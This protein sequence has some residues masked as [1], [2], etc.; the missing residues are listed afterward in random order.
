[1]SN[2]KP[3]SS[4]TPYDDVFR[5]LLNDCSSLIIPVINEVFG[6]DYRGD[7]EVL[8][9]PNEHFIQGQDTSTK[10]KI[11]D[12][13]FQ[14]IGIR[15][16]KYHLECQSTTDNK[17][18]VRMFEY[19]TQIALDAGEVVQGTL[20][21]EFPHS[22]VL[23]LRHN[24]R[25]PDAMTVRIKTP[26]GEISYQ[27]LV[28]KT[29]QYT[30]DE[31]F[32]KKLLFLIPFYIFTHE[33]RF[34]E[35]ENNADKRELLRTEVIG[36]MEKLEQMASTGEISE[37]EKCTIV[38]MS[39]KVVEKIAAKYE[40]V[41]K[42]VTSVMGGKV[43]EYEA[44]TILQNGIKKGKIEGKIDSIL[45][46]LEELGTVSDELCSCIQEEKDMEVLK[47]YLKKAS[48]A[49]SVQ[50]FEQWILQEM[51]RMDAVE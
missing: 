35:Y 46:L 21:V 11:T 18:I 32:E 40:N 50:E 49:Q 48:R 12:S 42:E 4:S 16:K 26:G 8:F 45:E 34:D 51:K 29:Q 24:S 20:T 3:T 19:D 15:K 39:R 14:V 22:A 5:T 25:T 44:K 17:M 7:E 13:C 23:Y 47:L 38:D 10:E 28:M 33:S 9:Y 27:V 37:Y 6:E 30:I 1:M 2:G 41:R 36:T 43:L 31:I